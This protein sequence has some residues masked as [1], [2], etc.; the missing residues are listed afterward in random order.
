MMKFPVI[1]ITASICIFLC[2]GMPGTLISGPPDVYRVIHVRGTILVKAPKTDRTG[3]AENGFHPMKIDDKISEMDEIVFK[4]PDAVAAVMSREK[5]RFTL[6]AENLEKGKDGCEL[7]GFVKTCLLPPRKRIST[8]S[9][10]EQ[11]AKQMKT[12]ISLLISLLRS[13]ERKEDEIRKECLEFLTEMY[14]G[15]ENADKAGIWLE[16]IYFSRD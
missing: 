14:F 9:L 11:D 10:S 1:I 4:T 15:E 12:E 5:G 8:R 7:A 2:L 16:Q 6:R 3:T 13:W